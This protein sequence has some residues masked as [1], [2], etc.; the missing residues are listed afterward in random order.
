VLK[1]KGKQ[2]TTNAGEDMGEKEPSH[3]WWECKFVQPL[4]KTEWSFLKKAQIELPYDPA[5][6]LLGTA[7]GT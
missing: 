1:K 5:A 4:W 7:E 3:R 2:I 6:P